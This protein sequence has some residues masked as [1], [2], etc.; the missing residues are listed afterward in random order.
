MLWDCKLSDLSLH[1][2]TRTLIVGIPSL[3]TFKYLH[4]FSFKLIHLTSL[5]LSSDSKNT[6]VIILA[7]IRRHH[8]SSNELHF[9]SGG[10]ILEEIHKHIL[11][12]R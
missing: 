1:A 5:A 12:W 11:D 8:Y 7:L 10:P 2:W 6:F 4:I 3:Q 9:N